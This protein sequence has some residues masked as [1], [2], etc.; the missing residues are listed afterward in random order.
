MNEPA[1]GSIK[2]YADLYAYI[3]QE[4]A[5]WI[6]NSSETLRKITQ[7]IYVKKQELDLNLKPH[8]FNVENAN[9]EEE[10]FTFAIILD[11]F[12]N[13]SLK[14]INASYAEKIKANLKKIQKELPRLLPEIKFNASRIVKSG[15]EMLFLGPGC[16]SNS[17]LRLELSINHFI[18]GDVLDVLDTASKFYPQKRLNLS[19]SV[20]KGADLS[21]SNLFGVKLIEVD[22]SWA[23]L[24]GADLSWAILSKADL[25][26]SN[27][28][29][30]NLDNAHLSE[31]IFFSEE[32]LEKSAKELS[33]RFKGIKITTKQMA[34][35]SEEQKAKLIEVLIYNYTETI[36]EAE[37]IVSNIKPKKR[38][39]ELPVPEFFLDLLLASEQENIEAWQVVARNEYLED[40]IS[41]KKQQVEDKIKSL[42]LPNTTITSAPSKEIQL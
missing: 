29:G 5:S 35:L 9:S 12:Y 17:S 4:L 20:F 8:I 30:A 33:H 16:F 15:E 2:T 18:A 37:K 7:E 40:L 24:S 11:T 10:V 3:A 34:L 23:N 13:I 19:G 1:S 31:T 22:F 25:S 32:E 39:F 27:L 38:N 41:I 42:N 36:K 14:E 6:M 21:G 28:L 26:G